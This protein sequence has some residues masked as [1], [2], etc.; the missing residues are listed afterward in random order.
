LDPDPVTDVSQAIEKLYV[1]TSKEA[2][3]IYRILV[4]LFM[5]LRI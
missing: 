3:I 1:N 2:I 5:R 4:I